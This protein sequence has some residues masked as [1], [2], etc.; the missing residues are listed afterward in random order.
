MADMRIAPAAAS[1]LPGSAP[2][3]GVSSTTP[4]KT[5]KLHEAAQQFEALMIGEMMKSVRQSS[6]S[7][8]LGSSGEDGSTDQAVE[9]AES[10]FAK[11]L[12]MSGG[13][14]LSRMVEKT[15]AAQGEQLQAGS[16]LRRRE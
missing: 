13:F 6:E 9:M 4:K 8:W 3:S 11:A 2:T 15:V 10:N 12:A 7:G 5:D 14:G 1:L 16:G